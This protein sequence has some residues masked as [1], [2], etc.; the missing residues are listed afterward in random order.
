MFNF[1]SIQFESRTH[2]NGMCMR[3]RLLHMDNVY[4][5]QIVVSL[6]HYW[7]RYAHTHTRTQIHAYVRKKSMHSDTF[8]SCNGMVGEERGRRKEAA[9]NETRSECSRHLH[10]SHNS[11][12]NNNKGFN[13]NKKRKKMK[14]EA[15][16][17]GRKKRKRRKMCWK[18][19]SMTWWKNMLHI[20]NCGCCCCCRRW[21]TFTSAVRRYPN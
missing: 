7:R 13:Y 15:R 5:A 14:K 10:T 12:N 4:L 9:E 16:S 18:K 6:F 8:H 1:N 2:P 19:R 17:E 3:E 11:P 21:V 20:C